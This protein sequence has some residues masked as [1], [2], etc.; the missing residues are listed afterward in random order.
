MKLNL[1]DKQ[2]KVVEAALDLY[3]RIGMG[4]LEDVAHVLGRH[5]EHVNSWDLIQ[6]HIYRLKRAAFP[7]SAAHI[8]TGSWG[9]SNK[10]V[11][12]SFRVAYEIQ[13]VMRGDECPLKIT[14]E[15][16]ATVEK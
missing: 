9:I 8:G 4:Q 3:S 10:Q 14:Q 11:P 1:T 13:Q 2:A 5:F 7:N 12:E 6:Q 15:P 16:L